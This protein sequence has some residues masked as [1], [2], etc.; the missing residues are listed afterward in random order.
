MVPTAPL[1]HENGAILLFVFYWTPQQV[2][3]CRVDFQNSPTRNHRINLTV[4]GEYP[5]PSAA[6]LKE[7]LWPPTIKYT[8][9]NRHTIYFPKHINLFN[10]STFK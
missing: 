7:A 5:K 1:P 4:I 8:Q 10:T 2:Y 3:R 9:K 6:P